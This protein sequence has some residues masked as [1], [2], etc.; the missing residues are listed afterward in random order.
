MY[1]HGGALPKTSGKI[2]NWGRRSNSV[3]VRLPDIDFLVCVILQN[4]LSI[5]VDHKE[6]PVDK[7]VLGDKK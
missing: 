1:F 3:D 5:R 4:M 2:T 7:I 6:I